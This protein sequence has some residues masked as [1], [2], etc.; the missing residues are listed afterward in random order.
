[1]GFRLVSP[2]FKDGDM[3]DSRFTCDGDNVSPTL[4]WAEVPEGTISLAFLCDDPDAP[5]GTFNH[6]ILY[7]VPPI[8]AELREGVPALKT[9]P[10]NVYQGVNSFGSMGYG[11]PCPPSGT[12][13]YIF[14]VFALSKLLDLDPGASKRQVENAIQNRILGKA[15]LMGK[16]SRP[17]V[18]PDGKKILNLD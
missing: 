9:L 7:N 13:R 15:Q 5:G 14:T 1:M 18:R 11:G 10:N 8:P 2:S 3:M 6:W 4:R 12:H 17:T 16:Y